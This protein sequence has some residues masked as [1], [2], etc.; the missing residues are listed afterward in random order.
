STWPAQCA[1]RRRAL[2]LL[3]TLGGE[4]FARVMSRLDAAA[5][6]THAPVAFTLPER[7]LVPAPQL[8]RPGADLAPR[9]APPH[10]GAPGPPPA[11]TGPEHLSTGRLTIRGTG[12]TVNPMVERS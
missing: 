10:R 4:R 5:P 3:A 6:S 11:L 9:A 2:V 1:S 7:D 8:R 12:D